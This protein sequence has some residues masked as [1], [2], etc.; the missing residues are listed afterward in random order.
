MKYLPYY[1][2]NIRLLAPTSFTTATKERKQNI[3]NGLGAA[4]MPIKINT[5]WGLNCRIIADIHDWAYYFSEWTFEAKKKH[6]KIFVENLS[7]W[8][9]AKSKN[10]ILRWLRLRRVSKYY[11][12]LKYAGN[13]AF[14]YNKQK[15]ESL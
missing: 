12:L 3:C 14:W 15:P 13:P 6:D 1:V 4:W 10:K 2:D 9:I 5:I 11:M 7:K 8:I